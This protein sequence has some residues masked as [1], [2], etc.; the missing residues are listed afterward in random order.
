MTHAQLQAFA[1]AYIHVCVCWPCLRCTRPVK[2]HMHCGWANVVAHT[3][4]LL[5]LRPLSAHVLTWPCSLGVPAPQVWLHRA[6]A[7]LDRALQLDP[8]NVVADVAWR[9]KFRAA[10][11]KI[12]FCAS[13]KETLAILPPHDV[14]FFFEI[15]ILGIPRGGSWHSQAPS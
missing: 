9:R 8:S 14:C 1:H 12:L 10:A 4:T 13:A 11:P 6:I 2:L 15:V 3:Q 7:S 5:M